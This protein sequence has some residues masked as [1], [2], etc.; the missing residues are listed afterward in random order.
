ML[1]ACR[2]GCK[3]GPLFADTPDDADALFGALRARAADG[4]AV[5]LDVPEPNAAALALAAR[6]GLR[7]VFET[8]RMYTG[9]TPDLALARTYGVTSFELG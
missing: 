7:A 8:A 1:R 5:C 3:I 4:E 2:S 9:A 6:A